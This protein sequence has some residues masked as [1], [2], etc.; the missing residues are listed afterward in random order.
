MCS[1]QLISTSA[2]QLLYDGKGRNV[3]SL[4]GLQPDLS[5]RL[6]CRLCSS[7][8]LLAIRQAVQLIAIT[9]EEPGEGHFS[10]Q[11]GEG[12][13]KEAV[14]EVVEPGGIDEESRRDGDGGER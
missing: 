4:A 9:P 12:E 14:L 13:C 8:I 6:V 3:A 2:S 10:A 5:Y 7:T 11:N 1:G